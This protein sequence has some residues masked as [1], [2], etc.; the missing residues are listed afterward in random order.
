VKI[1][2]V[3]GLCFFALQ[4]TAFAIDDFL[5]RLGE[6]L[7]I[8][9][10]DNSVRVR[11]R[12]T[13]DMEIY[14]VDG[15]GPELIFIDD[16]FLWNPRLS[17]LLDAQLG[18]NIYVFGQARLDRGFDPMQSHAEVRL[19]EYALRISPWLDARFNLQLGKFATVVGNW[20]ARHYSWDNPF[21][22]APLPYENLT[23]IWDSEAADSARTLLE[24]AHVRTSEGFG[25][26]EFH[27]RHLRQP[28]IWGPSYASGMAVFG[29]LWKFDYAVEVKNTSLSSRPETWD[30]TETTWENPTFSSR[31]GFRPNEMWNLGISGSAG[32]YLRPEANSTIAP[33][34]SL[35]DYREMV[36]AQDVAFA[37]RHLQIWAEFYE[38][39]FEIPAVGDVDTFAY[40]L[41]TKYKFTPQL[42]GAL[43]WNQQIFGTVRDNSGRE[44][45][46]GR[47]ARRV[48]VAIGYRLT[49]HTQMK[50]QYSLQHEDSGAR[51]YGH[52]IAAQITMRF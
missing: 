17:L 30:A 49:A 46:W 5:D 18:R 21:V 8:A 48:D 42:F 38:A 50:L 6:S 44:T 25:G 40:Y 20:V 47:D 12:G 16:G 28:I 7:T 36:V 32:T 1:I 22:T 41:E 4:A 14:H 13:L 23:A 33:G 39:R 45:T 10:F 27:D 24:W 3:F 26:D 37:W 9:A 15:P 34:Y 52:T 29:R 11:L 43:R 19:D 35:S 2:R 51:E 31:I